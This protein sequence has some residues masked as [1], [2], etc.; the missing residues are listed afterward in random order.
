MLHLMWKILPLHSLP[1]PLSSPLCPSVPL[2]CALSLSPSLPLFLPPCTLWYADM[3]EFLG[4]KMIDQTCQPWLLLL[5]MAALAVCAPAIG[6]RLSYS[7]CD[8]SQR[9]CPQFMCCWQKCKFH[10]FCLYKKPFPSVDCD[11]SF[12][13]LHR[14]VRDFKDTCVI[15]SCC[16]L[17]MCVN[18]GVCRTDQ[19]SNLA[20][21]KCGRQMLYCTGWIVFQGIYF[22]YLLTDWLMFDV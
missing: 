20:L 2:L 14:L 13:S 16:L 19:L 6:A 18:G 22:C 10:F 5:K 12:F 17:L 4:L 8:W 11:Y 7:S 15:S 21:M 9:V 3:Q 1:F